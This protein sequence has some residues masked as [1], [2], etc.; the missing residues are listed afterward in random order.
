M[1]RIVEVAKI[2]RLFNVDKVYHM[3]GKPNL[4]CTGKGRLNNYFVHKL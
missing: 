4:H 1:E 3:E 2:N